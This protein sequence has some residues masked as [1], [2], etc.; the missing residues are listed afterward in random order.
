MR[1]FIV[2]VDTGIAFAV[3]EPV[4]WS[5]FTTLSSTAAT[6][7]EEPTA[8]VAMDRADAMRTSRYICVK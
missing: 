4:G 6:I 1:G 2:I 3:C 5:S 7:S 8:R